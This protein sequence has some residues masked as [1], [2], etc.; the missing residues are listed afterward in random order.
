[1]ATPFTEIL[2]PTEEGLDFI[3]D[4]AGGRRPVLEEGE[5]IATFEVA[6]DETAT[7]AGLRV[8]DD[9]APAKVED[10]KALKVYLHVDEAEEDDERFIRGV[11]LLILADIVT[12]AGRGRRKA[13]RI[14]V[15][16]AR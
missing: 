2:D 11:R 8:S 10:D 7:A 3:L 4:F 5:T 16:R 9:P 15:R 12:S 14:R 1:M 6:P 13:F